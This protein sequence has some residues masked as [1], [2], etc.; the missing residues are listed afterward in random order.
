MLVF[1]T[2][3]RVETHR[4]VKDPILLIEQPELIAYRLVP[5][6]GP[7]CEIKIE[8][9]E[10]FGWEYLPEPQREETL[11]IVMDRIVFEETNYWG[12]NEP[13]IIDDI[14]Y[15][16]IRVPY[17]DGSLWVDRKII[18]QEIF[19]EIKKEQK[20]I[21]ILGAGIHLLRL[22]NDGYILKCSYIYFLGIVIFIL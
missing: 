20:K 21:G 14:L 17:T 5:S 2:F 10:A 3:A 11:D 16:L 4:I 9:V 18:C 7:Y 19:L 1:T 8:I 15:I 6:Y 12:V 22:M 13:F